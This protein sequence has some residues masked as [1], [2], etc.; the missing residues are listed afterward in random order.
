M[1]T[2]NLSDRFMRGILQAAETLPPSAEDS[3]QLQLLAMAKEILRLRRIIGEKGKAPRTWG[4][5]VAR[6]NPAAE[7]AT[8]T[9]LDSEIVANFIRK[10]Q[11]L[12]EAE[13]V[14]AACAIVIQAKGQDNV[15]VKLSGHPPTIRLLNEMIAR[16]A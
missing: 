11:A 7:Y 2:P 13:H 14:P 6:E 8:L 3:V 16:G 12:S 15:A 5:G 9:N 4:E 1:A 10:F